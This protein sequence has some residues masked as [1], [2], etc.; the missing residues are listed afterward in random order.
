MTSYNGTLGIMALS[1]T[2]GPVT[3]ACPLGLCVMP[4]KDAILRGWFSNLGVDEMG[5][6]QRQFGEVLLMIEILKGRT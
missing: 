4:F 2:W 3:T 1:Y 5:L 6:Y